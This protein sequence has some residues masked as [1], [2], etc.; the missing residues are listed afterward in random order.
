M[1]QTTIRVYSTTRDAVRRLADEDGL[2]LDEEIRQLTK[3]ERQR[4]MGAALAG[5]LSRDDQRWLDATI[6]TV[7]DAARR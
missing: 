7:R 3:R 2:T 1:Q 4:R 6:D 5:E